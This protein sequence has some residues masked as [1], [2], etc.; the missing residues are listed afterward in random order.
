MGPT[1]KS[2]LFTCSNIKAGVLVYTQTHKQR[3]NNQQTASQTIDNVT[4]Y[5][6]ILYYVK[7]SDDVCSSLDILQNLYLS[8]D[9]LFLDGLRRTRVKIK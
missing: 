3:H 6:G 5:H 9:L 7:Q 8:F 1:L 2:V 4:T